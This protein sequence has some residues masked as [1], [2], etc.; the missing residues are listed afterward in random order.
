M[1]DEMSF[2]KLSEKVKALSEEELK[3]LANEET[4]DG[5]KKVMFS[6]ACDGVLVWDPD[7][8]RYVCVP[9]G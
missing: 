1:S 9:I 5:N 2:A 4:A 7:R 8:G 3:E 6:D